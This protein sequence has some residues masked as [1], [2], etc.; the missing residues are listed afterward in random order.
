[1][2]RNDIKIVAIIGSPRRGDSYCVIQV[3]ESKLKA[4]EK[5]VKFDYIFLRDLK[6]DF[7]RGC[8]QCFKEGEEFCPEKEK[9][10]KIRDKM[11]ESDGVIFASPVYAHNV[12]ALYKNF[13]D[14]FSYMFHRPRFFDKYA[15]VLATTGGAGLEIVLKYLE[16]AKFWGFNV[17][18]KIGVIGW[19][20]KYLSDYRKDK[21]QEIEKIA[22]K[23][24][25]AI[26]GKP[27][28]KPDAE[29]IGFFREMKKLMKSNYS[30]YFPADY[31]YWK[32]MGWFNMEYFVNVEH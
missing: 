21:E 4:I 11:L 30:K 12:T 24:V 28:H 16:S 6:I 32:E 15:V 9:T 26:K 14:H 2:K 5:A 13:I 10:L 18:G 1:M 17:V 23:L 19:K 31:K 25:R 7:C 20:F 22:E 27:P 3:F 29:Q 8:M